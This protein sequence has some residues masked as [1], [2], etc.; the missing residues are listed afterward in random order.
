[1]LHPQL[2]DL[3]R[4]QF[5]IAVDGT[6]W[7]LPNV[8]SEPWLQGFCPISHTLATVSWRVATAG[9]LSLRPR[10]GSRTI[11]GVDRHGRV[12][13]TPGRHTLFSRQS[14]Y[15]MLVW[16]MRKRVKYII[17]GEHDWL[18]RHTSL[19]IVKAPA[20]RNLLEFAVEV[21]LCEPESEKA[22]TEAVPA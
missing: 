11:Y 14:A 3:V 7:A 6:A 9:L 12:L 1:M 20:G 22:E 4:T 21:M 5:G 16:D 15:Q 17:V 18:G 2:R 8:L 13:H 19:T 10:R